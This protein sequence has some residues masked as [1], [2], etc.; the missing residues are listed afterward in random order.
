MKR[1]IRGR[2]TDSSKENLQQGEDTERVMKGEKYR[3]QTL[4]LQNKTSK[5][6]GE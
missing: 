1:T 2:P 4:K 5:F 3:S 6:Q